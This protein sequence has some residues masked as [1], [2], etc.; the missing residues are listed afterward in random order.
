MTAEQQRPAAP[1]AA[2]VLRESFPAE[3]VSVPGVRHRVA[4]FAR[5][6]GLTGPRLDAVCSMASLTSRALDSLA[7]ARS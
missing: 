6:A 1:P 7:A 3:A 5:A 4:D 2:A